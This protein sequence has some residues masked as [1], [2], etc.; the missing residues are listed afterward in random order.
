MAVAVDEQEQQ[1]A[2]ESMLCLFGSIADNEYQKIVD[3][4]IGLDGTRCEQILS[5]VLTE[6]L[7][8]VLCVQIEFRVN[9]GNMHLFKD[10]AANQ[11]TFGVPLTDPFKRAFCHPDLDLTML[12]EVI[13]KTSTPPDMSMQGVIKLA[14]FRYND[15]LRKKFKRTK[16]VTN[17]VAY[18][19]ERLLL[20]GSGTQTLSGAVTDVIVEM[21]EDRQMEHTVVRAACNLGEWWK[22][23]QRD[24]LA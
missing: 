22:R 2:L 13:A 14:E 12:F 20:R 24:H 6:I 7:K 18:I 15:V 21:A 16:L 23:Y 5:S 8:S 3:D 17:T 1:H 10:Q 19:A 9:G 4:R 11:F